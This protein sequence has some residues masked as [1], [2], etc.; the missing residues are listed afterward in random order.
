MNPRGISAFQQRRPYPEG[1]L[2]IGKLYKI[3]TDEVELSEEDF[4]FRNEGDLRGTSYM[5]KDTNAKETGGWVYALFGPDRKRI[6]IDV[7]KACFSCHTRAIDT[8]Y[9]F[10]KPLK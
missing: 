2:F 3:E 10:S 7:K 9:I 5:R 6:E 1:T 8:D 4:S